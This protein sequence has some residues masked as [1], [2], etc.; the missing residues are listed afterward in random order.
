MLRALEVGL[1]GVCLI[2]G[3]LAG[4]AW[5]HSH[6]AGYEETWSDPATQTCGRIVSARGVL[7][8]Q[9]CDLQSHRRPDDV[10]LQWKPLMPA[11]FV[12]GTDPA[13]PRAVINCGPYAVPFA[14]PR[15]DWM[16]GFTTQIDDRADVAT[17]SRWSYEWREEA[18]AYWFVTAVLLAAPVVALIVWTWWRV[19]RTD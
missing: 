7:F 9:T 16:W 12:V 17:A 5:L 13:G 6:L 11:D 8:R 18:V 2:L 14:F 4:A 10:A 1:L 19:T 15:T 3:C